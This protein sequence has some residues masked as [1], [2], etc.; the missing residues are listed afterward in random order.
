MNGAPLPWFRL[1][2]ADRCEQRVREPKAR[3]IE[4]DDSFP[5]RGVESL[6]NIGPVAMGGRHQLDGRPSERGCEE[7]DVPGL[8]GHSCEA[9]V[10]QLA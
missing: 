4:L 5:R 9:A 1:L 7:H 3:V 10:E 2:V 8:S 6:E